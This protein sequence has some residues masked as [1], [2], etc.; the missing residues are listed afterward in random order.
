MI[1]NIR[2]ILDNSTASCVLCNFN[3]DDA[4]LS[5]IR[6]TIKLLLFLTTKRN[7]VANTGPVSEYVRYVVLV[8]KAPEEMR[9]R[10]RGVEG[11]ILALVR[12]RLPVNCGWSYV[13]LREGF[14]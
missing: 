2:I 1:N 10:P 12:G 7:S 3:D 4:T 9:L 5:E 6:Q 14:I 8:H 11:D 13:V